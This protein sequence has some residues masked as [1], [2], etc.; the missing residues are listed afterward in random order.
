MNVKQLERQ[1]GAKLK[2][3]PAPIRVATDGQQAPA[4]DEEWTLDAILRQPSR[5]RLT[6]IASCLSVELQTDNIREYRSPE[7]LILRCQLTIAGQNIRLE[8]EYSD[9]DTFKRLEVQM[10]ALLAEMRR[11]LAACPLRREIVLL[12]RSRNYWAKGNELLYYTDDHPDLL[13]Q[14]Q[15]LS[16]HGLA[17]D[18]TH[19]NATRY[20][21]AEDLA[22][23]LGA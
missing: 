2:L 17:K 1:I 18:I 14:F 4:P 7:F 5:V 13:S 15:I 16:N 22:R 8:P 23:Y 9:N 11:D 6:N 19:N 21:L 12:Q 3:L 20:L 10:P